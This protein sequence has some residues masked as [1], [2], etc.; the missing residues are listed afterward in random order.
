VLLEGEAVL[1]L[2]A[3][4]Q[5]GKAELVSSEAL[6]FE[7]RRNQNAT[8]REYAI[9]TLSLARSFVEISDSVEERA[10]EFV[11]EGIAPLDAL[12]LACA[13]AA[14]ADYLCTCDDRFLR[15]VRG[16]SGLRAKPVSPLELVEE[17]DR[18]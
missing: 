4:C 12:H 17:A 8:R 16:L 13:E 2:L 3:L 14:S 1:G 15:R 10:R 5:S 11:A 6:T 18:W 7:V 9:D